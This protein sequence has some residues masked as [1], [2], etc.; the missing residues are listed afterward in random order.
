MSENKGCGCGGHE[1]ENHAGGCCGGGND[2]CGCGSR[3]SEEQPVI[4]ITF[5]GEEEE[6][7][8]DVLGVF[9]FNE[10]EYI[11]LVPQS[12]EYDGELLIY[13]YNETGDEVELDEIVSDEEYEQ[14]TDAFNELYF[15]L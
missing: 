15:G 3:N 1:E 7:A 4:Y 5:E 9:E 11:A 14:I 10:K 2:G 6:V 8:C 13:H 12:E